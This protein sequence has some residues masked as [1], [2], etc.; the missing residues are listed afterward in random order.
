MTKLKILKATHQNLNKLKLALKKEKKKTKT[1]PKTNRKQIL[2]LSPLPLLHQISFNL[3]N[4]FPIYLFCPSPQGQM[5]NSTT[6]FYHRGGAYQ[7]GV[8]V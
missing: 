4:S 1:P 3:T 6:L 8:G 7:D 5:G 2:T